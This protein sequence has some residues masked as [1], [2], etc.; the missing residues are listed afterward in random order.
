MP[1][2]DYGNLPAGAFHEI[3]VY[4]SPAATAQNAACSNDEQTTVKPTVD[5]LVAWVRSRPSLVV[6]APVPV[7][8]GGHP[9]QTIDVKLAPSWTAKCPDTTAPN[10][11]FLMDAGSAGSGGYTWGIGPG[12]RQRLTFLDLG[13][14]DI[15][16]IGIDSTYPDRF[17]DLVSQATPIIQSLTFK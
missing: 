15:A 14:G 1:T 10:A 8:V 6:S 5:G 13:S 7:T 3:S 17:D 2:A 12:E 11:V 4:G 9:G 16:L